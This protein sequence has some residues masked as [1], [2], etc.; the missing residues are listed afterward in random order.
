M[1]LIRPGDIERD[2]TPATVY[3]PE[4][5]KEW[6]ENQKSRYRKM[7]CGHYTDAITQERYSA[8]R[9][10]KGRWYCEN[11]EEWL[12]LSLREITHELP[13]KPPF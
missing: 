12:P 5:L 6:R 13:V 7:T 9:P 4:W 3:V 8:W 2:K 11:C 1:K 10:G